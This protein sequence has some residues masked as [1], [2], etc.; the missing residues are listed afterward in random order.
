[1]VAYYN[2]QQKNKKFKQFYSQKSNSVNTD[3][4]RSVQIVVDPRCVY[5]VKFIFH[6]S[7]STSLIFF[8]SF[9]NNTSTLF[10]S[11]LANTTSSH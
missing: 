3:H 1:M 4:K 5:G 8:I 10:V 2:L 9:V 6:H 11:I 7:K